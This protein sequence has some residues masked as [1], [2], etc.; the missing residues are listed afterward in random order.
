MTRQTANSLASVLGTCFL[1]CVGLQILSMGLYLGLHD[2]A[3]SIHSELF[4]LSTETFDREM[5]HFMGV[6][7]IL[8]L[9]LF[10]IPWA[11]L[12]LVARRL[13]E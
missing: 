10:L 2:W 4:S 13:P 11:A 8:G 9:V 3:Y 12:K 7:K 5:Y 1:L 6:F